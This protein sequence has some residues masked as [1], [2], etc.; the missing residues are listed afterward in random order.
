MYIPAAFKEE[1]PQKL[2]DFIKSHNFATLVSGEKNYLQASHLPFLLDEG[3]GKFGFLRGHMAK[4]NSHWQSI[5]SEEV[6]VL[7]QG[8]HA[9]ISPTWY[10]AED[11]VPTWNYAAVHAYGHYRPVQDEKGL[12]QI[13]RDLTQKHEAAMPNPWNMDTLSPAYLE[14]MC[15]MIVGFEIEITRLEGKWKLNQNHPAERREKVVKALRKQGSPQ[16]SQMADLM[17]GKNV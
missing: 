15:Q 13:L 6:L 5:G 3:R 12:Q 16:A 11:T 1:D 14:K 2:M 8:P 4:A 17:E 7:F 10:E 9:Y